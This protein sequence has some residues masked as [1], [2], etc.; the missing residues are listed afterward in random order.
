MFQGYVAIF[1]ESMST[2]G[3]SFFRWGKLHVTMESPECLR[4]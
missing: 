1:L 3:S 4:F 2:S